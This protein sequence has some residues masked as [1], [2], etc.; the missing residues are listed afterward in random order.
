MH[1]TGTAPLHFLCDAAQYSFEC[2]T[3]EDSLAPVR[4]CRPMDTHVT[5]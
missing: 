3:T 5:R 1:D 2:P 4:L